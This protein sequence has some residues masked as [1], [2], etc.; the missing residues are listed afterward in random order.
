MKTAS[1]KFRSAKT[2]SLSN[3]T[4]L[5]ERR[6][7]KPLTISPPDCK[8]RLCQQARHN[9]RRQ[10][11]RCLAASANRKTQT[12]RTLNITFRTIR[13]PVATKRATFLWRGAEPRTQSS[14][15]AAREPATLRLCDVWAA[16]SSWSKSCALPTTY[17]TAL[18]QRLYLAAH[19]KGYISTQPSILVKFCSLS[20]R[21]SNPEE[22]IASDGATAANI[23]RMNTG[24]YLSDISTAM[25]IRAL[26]ISTS[27]PS[28]PTR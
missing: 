8:P 16:L 2:S 9:I 24:K 13:Q 18:Y 20:M 25:P 23:T 27:H 22:L 28:E 17:N 10:A 11:P 21:R 12:N 4:G 5:G 7:M 19:S 14:R 6:G 3:L 15:S 26:T 1:G